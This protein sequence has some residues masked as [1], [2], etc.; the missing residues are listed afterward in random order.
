MSRDG[1]RSLVVEIAHPKHLLQFRHLI[2]ALSD[3]H[4]VEVIARDKDVVV[5]LLEQHR[6]NYTGYGRNPRGMLRKLAGVPLTLAEYRKILRRVRPDFI[7]SKSSPYSVLLARTVG[8]RTMIFPDSEGV[9]LNDRFVY[10]RADFMI[11]PPN[12]EFDYGEKHF[13]LGGVFEAGYLHPDHFRPDPQIWPQLGI[14]A[15]ERFALLRFVAW[16][17]NHDVQRRGVDD[18]DKSKLVR[19]LAERMHVFISAEGRL[20]S[21]LEEHRLRLPASKLH[22]VLHAASLYFGDSQTVA[23]EAALLGTPSIRCNSF[24]GISDMSNFKVLEADFGLLHNYADFGSAFERAESLADDEGA[25]QAW[26]ER[27]RAYFDV[28][29]DVNEEMLEVVERLIRNLKHM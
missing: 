2:R 27:R 24:V 12:V 6:I 23:T 16:N 25:K 21:S 1:R 19:A 14:D 28:A 4:S 20:D 22:D 5:D 9:P 7:L 18:A 11:T 29:G 3:A 13:R 10:P 17:A 15:G 8:A 26:E